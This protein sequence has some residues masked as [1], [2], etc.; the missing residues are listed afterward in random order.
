MDD[1]LRYRNEMR[2]Q[3]SGFDI[4]IDILAAFPPAPVH[5]DI[6]DDNGRLI[7]YF[8]SSDPVKNFFRR[9]PQDAIGWSTGQIGYLHN[10]VDLLMLENVY[11]RSSNLDLNY[12]LK[13]AKI[14]AIS[15]SF[16]DIF[17]IKLAFLAISSPTTA[18]GKDSK[19]RTLHL[20]H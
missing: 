7:N 19:A 2:K 5:F 13:H 3:G 17:M 15:D 18:L 9:M 6:L 10:A 11:K 1:Y 4:A 14:R 12:L 20:L 8:V 16:M